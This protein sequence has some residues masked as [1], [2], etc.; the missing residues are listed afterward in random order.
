MAKIS[1][2]SLRDSRILEE[3]SLN[4]KSLRD[5]ARIFTFLRMRRDR[6]KNIK[7][8]LETYLKNLT[9][10]DKKLASI[11]LQLIN[12]AKERIKVRKLVCEEFYK[13]QVSGKK[14]Y[15]K[16][17]IYLKLF[18]LLRKQLSYK[19][20]LEAISKLSVLYGEANGVSCK[21]E[22]SETKQRIKKYYPSYS[23]EG[24]IIFLHKWQRSENNGKL[25]KVCGHFKKLMCLG[26][27]CEKEK[28]NI[29]KRINRI[30]KTS[31][32]GSKNEPNWVRLLNKPTTLKMNF[33]NINEESRQLLLRKKVTFEKNSRYCR[34]M[35]K[36][37]NENSAR[38]KARYINSRLELDIIILNVI[39]MQLDLSCYLTD[40]ISDVEF[41]KATGL[42]L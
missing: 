2:E 26:H 7:E 5:I 38:R 36:D 25:K 3:F 12:N 30:I 31:V 4:S 39:L 21:E 40:L 23:K 1:V 32:M 22:L 27:C 42:Y 11:P 16:D 41:I 28:T 13:Y 20:S 10:A 8:A 18:K 37:N 9:N 24:K 35:N 33:F 17:L 15:L 29:I 19:E 6:Q 14:D 34:A